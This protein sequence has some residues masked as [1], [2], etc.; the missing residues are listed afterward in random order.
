MGLGIVRSWGL[1]DSGPDILGAPGAHLTYLPISPVSSFLR[2]TIVDMP[3]MQDLMR[4]GVHQIKADVRFCGNANFA[5]EVCV[6]VHS[7]S[8]LL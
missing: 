3:M 6:A 7:V 8:L 1:Y 2:Y 4:C 5:I